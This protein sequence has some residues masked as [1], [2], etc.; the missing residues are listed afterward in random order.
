MQPIIIRGLDGPAVSGTRWDISEG[1]RDLERVGTK[2]KAVRR[3]RN[4]W[5]TPDQPIKV[6]GTTGRV[7]WVREGNSAGRGNNSPFRFF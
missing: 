5:S 6:V 2:K 7:E 3:A 4:K 1:M